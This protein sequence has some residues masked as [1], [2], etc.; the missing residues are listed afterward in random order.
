M[1]KLNIIRFNDDNHSERIW[2]N[3]KYIGTLSDISFIFN[4]LLD[5]I[6]G[7][8]E[9]YTEIKDTPVY[10]CDDF[11]DI[12]EDTADELWEWFNNVEQISDEQIKLITERDWTKLIDKIY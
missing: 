11:Y 7:S 4:N 10:V 2:A 6:N 1:K 12:D 8:K 9:K 3:G 5:I